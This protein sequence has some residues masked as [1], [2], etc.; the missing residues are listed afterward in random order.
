MKAM[1]S[2]SVHSAVLL[3]KRIR[4]RGTLFGAA[5]D[6]TEKP[7]SGWPTPSYG[8]IYNFCEQFAAVACLTVLP[9]AKLLA[10]MRCGD[11][12]SI[13]DSVNFFAIFIDDSLN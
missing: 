9:P 7:A 10:Q 12:L 11:P 8:P 3:L 2:T 6:F 4:R 5:V 1:R 13:I